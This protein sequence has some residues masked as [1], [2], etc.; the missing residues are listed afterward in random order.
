LECREAAILFID[1]E[2]I[3]IRDIAVT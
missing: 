3:K 2:L 1:I